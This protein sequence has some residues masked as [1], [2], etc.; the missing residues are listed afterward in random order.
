MTAGVSSSVT[1][2]PRLAALDRRRAGV[3]GP[4]AS[5]QGSPSGTPGLGR[6]H[7]LLLFLAAL[8]IRCIYCLTVLRHYEPQSDARSY[9]QLAT[10]VAQGHGFSDGFP[11]R[12]WVH[13]TAFRPPLYPALLGAIFTVTGARLGVAEGVNAGL[14]AFVVVL[15]ALLAGRL[16][17]QHRGPLA[18]L[19]GGHRAALIAGGLLAVY[20]PLLA[21]DGPTL[22]EPLSL[23]LLLAGCL[24]LLSGRCLLA[25]AVFGLLVLTRPSAQLLVPALALWVLVR[26]D[27]RRAAA[28]TMVAVAIVLPWVVRNDLTFGRP[29]IVTSNGFNLAAAWSPVTL[30]Q[31]HVTD[32]VFDR[33]FAALRTGAAS[34]NEA[35][36]DANFSDAGLHG[37]RTHPAA[38]P[39]ILW[40]NTRY[41]MDWSVD[42]RHSSDWLDGRNMTL[43]HDALPLVWLVTAV[44]ACGILCLRRR[45]GGGLVLMLCGY[46]FAVSIVTV[47]PPRLRA[48]LDVL[49]IIGVG[50]VLA[51]L[52]LPGIARRRPTMI[53]LT[54]RSDLTDLTDRSTAAVS[55]S[56]SVVAP[57]CSR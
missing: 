38:V 55:A 24:A 52:R 11:Y 8:A 46:F 7:L 23:V 50:V 25:G 35:A 51:R 49:F 10:S 14:G 40:R 53:D 4:A 47:S 19:L 44:G 34:R 31:H 41:L 17:G 43:R 54:D 56:S 9:L 20:P 32:P 33:R 36:L 27:W 15:V 1:I 45:P 5:R 57:R 42:D 16:A 12:G 6:R 2:E 26:L 29:L 21:N 3:D 13:P 18:G 37:L 28:F 30:A 48:P 22:S 39:G